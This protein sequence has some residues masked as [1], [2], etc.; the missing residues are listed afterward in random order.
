MFHPTSTIP[1]HT[2]RNDLKNHQLCAFPNQLMKEKHLPITNETEQMLLKAQIEALLQELEVVEQ[3][4]K[5]FEALIRSHLIE[6]LIEEQ[7]LTVLYKKLKQAKKEKRLEQKRRGKNYKESLGI[8]LVAKP[9]SEPINQEE[10]KEK[11]RLYREAMVQVHPDKF[12]MHEEIIDSATEVTSKLIEIY[13]S[14][15]LHELRLFHAHIFSGNALLQVLEK[16]ANELTVQI[17]DSYL[18][19]EKLKL[20]KLV[21]QAKQ[22]HTYRVLTE[23]PNPLLFVDELKDYYADRIAKLRKRTRK[24]V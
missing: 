16:P 12:S 1:V 4:T 8:K 24:A 23:Y 3:K 19:N 22:R 9:K 7:E 21:E 5:A 14:G 20:T 17:E 2:F 11:K 13:Q 6:E 18:Q 15:S 10:Q